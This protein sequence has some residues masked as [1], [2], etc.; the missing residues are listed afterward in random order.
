[1]ARRRRR[2]AR[3]SKKRKKS[4]LKVLGIVLLLSLPVLYF[5]F[6]KF[7]YDPFEG[8]VGPFPELVPREVDVYVR[9]ERLDSDFEIFPMP[10]ELARLTATP[11]FREVAQSDWYAQQAWITELAGLAATL[12][13]ALAEAPF[14]LLDD[15][16]GAEVV[17]LGRLP[18]GVGDPR[19][20][21][22]ARLSAKGRAAYSVLDQPAVRDRILPGAEVR[23]V[24][25]PDYAK[26]T[27]QRVDLSDGTTWFV[28]REL[29]ML[30]VGKDEPLV[31]D[32]LRTTLVEREQSLGLTR[33]YAQDLPL[34]EGLPEDH[35]NA[36]LFLDVPAYLASGEADEDLAERSVNA[37]TNILRQ[38]VDVTLLQDMIARVEMEQGTLRF[39]GHAMVDNQRAT[40][41]KTG[42]VGQPT[43]VLKEQLELIFGRVPR[44][45]VGMVTAK[46]D[47]GDLLTT[48]FASFSNDIKTITNEALRGVARYNPGWNRVNNAA[49]LIG[50]LEVVLRDE[51][52]F[53]MRPL[54]HELPVDVQPV[55]AIVMIAPLG[56]YQA[57]KDLEDAFMRGMREF[58]LGVDGLTNWSFN[59]GVGERYWFETSGLPFTEFS[60][61]V[62]GEKL[63]VMGIDDDLVK[64]IV[65]VYT[66]VKPSIATK[67][68]IQELI[69]SA[70]T[71][72]ANLAMWVD[73][74]GLGEILG[75]YSR[76]VAD[77]ETRIDY[78]VLRIQRRRE[79]IDRDYPQYRGREELPGSV[80][81][82]I[83][84]KLDALLQAEEA[85]RRAT[86]V[87]AEAERWLD[88]FAW[89]D[90]LSDAF[91]AVNLGTREA[92][93]RVIVN[94]VSS[95]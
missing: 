8:S 93:A 42:L 84:A 91:A 11:G 5:L 18:A 27:Y 2:R 47:I 16:L 53:V 76:W 15:L 38:V 67:P 74:K 29:D 95:R 19:F 17:V 40:G 32:V 80:E 14:D 1:M 41:V 85:D 68:Q 30:V 61:I 58:G 59:E 6:T 44:S 77:S 69:D 21:Y 51:I 25:D 82:D 55:P 78:G 71:E 24:E 62:L 50:L 81:A 35:F 33:L 65:D 26:V 90:A 66:S 72:R 12:E 70:G 23:Q 49:D 13:G 4:T 43:F 7:V 54:D 56:N 45:V 88:S 92:E 10:R 34:D 36:E 52:T 48:V 46:V 57:F 86:T 20:A 9:R 63:L 22:L 94:T 60:Y 37:A 83:E 31:R 64:E 73:A 89:L 79:I 87:P 75:P 28:S 39:N 3:S